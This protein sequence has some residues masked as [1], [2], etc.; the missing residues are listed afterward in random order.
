MRLRPGEALIDIRITQAE[1]GCALGVIPL[2]HLSERAGSHCWAENRFRR[3]G[4]TGRLNIW[5]NI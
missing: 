1:P 4:I 2:S 5:L 3:G